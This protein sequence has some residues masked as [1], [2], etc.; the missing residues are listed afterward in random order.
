MR[1]RLYK[2]KISKKLKAL[3]LRKT[4]KQDYGLF[5]QKFLNAHWAQWQQAR[6]IAQKGDKVLIGTSTGGQAMVAKNGCQTKFRMPYFRTQNFPEC[7]STG[8]DGF[9]IAAD[10]GNWDIEIC[11]NRFQNNQSLKDKK[12][13]P[14]GVADFLL[15]ASD[16][17]HKTQK[18]L[19][20]IADF[21]C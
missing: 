7:V 19:E 21:Y 9:E 17:Q 11:D 14:C 13:H 3:L 5:W 12:V 16:T 1:S 20:K 15:C 8:T 4:A 6:K 18:L 10:K 2:K